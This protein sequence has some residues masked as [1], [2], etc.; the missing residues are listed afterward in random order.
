MGW[1]L[2]L[3]FVF[4]YSF[5]LINDGWCGYPTL[6][7]QYVCLFIGLVCLLLVLLF[8]YLSIYFYIINNSVTIWVFFVVVWFCLFAGILFVGLFAFF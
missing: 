8:M 7:M 5:V 4:L 6:G 3:L 1:R 2:D